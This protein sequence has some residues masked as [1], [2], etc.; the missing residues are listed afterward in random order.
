MGR[1]GNGRG[2]QGRGAYRDTDITD[3]VPLARFA[4][5]GDV[6]GAVAFLADDE[7]SGYISGTNIS[8]DG[9]WHAAAG[10]HA[11]RMSKR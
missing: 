10:W 5:P 4:S 11:L 3:R 8:V 2:G 1:H 9:G 7:R 6:A